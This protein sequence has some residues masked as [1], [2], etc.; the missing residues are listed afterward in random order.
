[1]TIKEYKKELKTIETQGGVERSYYSPFERYVKH[2][3]HQNQLAVQ[4]VIEGG[5]IEKPSVPLVTKNQRSFPDIQLFSAGGLRLIGMVEAK[6]LGKDIDYLVTKNDKQVSKYLESC[7]NLLLTNFDRV[8]LVGKGGTKP[9]VIGDFSLFSQTEAAN[10]LIVQF[11][12]QPASATLSR[13]DVFVDNLAYFAKNM[14]SELLTVIKEQVDKAGTPFNNLYHQVFQNTLKIAG[15]SHAEFAYSLTESYTFYHLFNKQLK[16]NIKL[17][18]EMVVSLLD[19]ALAQPHS[20]HQHSTAQHSTAQHSTA[21]HSTAQHSTAQ[22]STAQHSTAQHSTAQHSTAQHST[23]QHS[24]A[25]HS[26]AQHSTAQHSTAQHSTA[27]HSTAQHSTAQHSTAQ[28]STAQHSTAQ[29]S[30]AQHSTAQHSTAQHSTAQ[31][32]TAQHSTAQHSTA[33]HSTAQHST[34]QHSTAQ[35]STAQHS[36]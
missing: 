15:Q 8:V 36:Y 5:V 26:T 21:Q 2:L 10:E 18:D 30:T 17:L 32:S 25:Q 31:H 14:Q 3:L 28:H 34:A 23:A 35:H 20:T 29:H 11:A 22:H 19:K 24:T 16:I 4:T 33:Q 27:Q 7:N 13:F 1:M 9:K 12:R 6:N